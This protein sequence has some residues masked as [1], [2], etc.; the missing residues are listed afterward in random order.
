[1]NAYAYFRLV[2]V[3][4]A[5][6]GLGLLF[7]TAL[8]SRSGRATA[9]GELLVLSR[10]SSVGLVVML[11]TGIAMNVSAKGLYGPQ[12]WFGLSV[13]SFFVTGAVVGITRRRLRKWIT[14]DVDPSLARRFVER[15]SWI[16]CA[17]IAW[18]TVLMELKPF[19]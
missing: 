10:W 17:L 14:G 7:A 5:V 12:P 3:V 4:C 15:A 8:L 11:L 18:I 13:A 9:P 2:H 16:A 1:M 19:S 6:L